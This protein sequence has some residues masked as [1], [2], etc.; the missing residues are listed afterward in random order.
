MLHLIQIIPCEQSEIT[1]RLIAMVPEM[2][3]LLKILSTFTS[4]YEAEDLK[5]QIEAVIAKAEGCE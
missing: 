5:Y 3:R 1:A 4:A 2:L